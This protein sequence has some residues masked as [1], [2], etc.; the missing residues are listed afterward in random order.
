MQR[1]L[2]AIL[3]RQAR[4]LWAIG[5][6]SVVLAAFLAVCSVAMLMSDASFNWRF[7][8]FS[9]VFV[10]GGSGLAALRRARQVERDL[11]ERRREP[12]PRAVV[13]TRSS[14]PK[15]D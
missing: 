9:G 14:P 6:A 8:S 15:A 12:I 11:A 5:V 4:Q 1:G 2:E 3:E 10:F 13:H 7:Y